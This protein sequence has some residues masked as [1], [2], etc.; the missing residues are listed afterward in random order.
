MRNDSS[1]LMNWAVPPLTVI[2]PAHLPSVLDDSLSFCSLP[3]EVMVPSMVRDV[4]SFMSSI[5]AF[6]MSS[7]DLSVKPSDPPS[8]LEPQALAPSTTVV[9]SAA[10]SV[11]FPSLMSFAPRRV[12]F[13]R[14]QWDHRYPLGAKASGWLRWG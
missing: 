9:A 10:A 1:P 12:G 14:P 2:S 8:S 3:S 6:L 5:A 7:A 13:V 11:L 4:T